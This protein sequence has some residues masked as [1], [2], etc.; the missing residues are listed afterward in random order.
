MVNESMRLCNR[1]LKFDN[2]SP[3]CLKSVGDF[4]IVA[5]I[6]GLFFNNEPINH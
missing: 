6:D 3:D 1:G 2:L 4:N 5:S